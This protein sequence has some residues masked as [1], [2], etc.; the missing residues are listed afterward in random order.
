MKLQ[1]KFQCKDKPEI[2]VNLDECEKCESKEECLHYNYEI[3]WAKEN[4]KHR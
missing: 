2:F 3:G 4:E 1:H